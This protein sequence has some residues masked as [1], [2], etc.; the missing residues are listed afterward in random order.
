M[1]RDEGYEVEHQAPLGYRL[2]EFDDRIIG[3]EVSHGLATRIV[4][5]RIIVLDQV[6]STND[7]AWQEALRGAPDGTVIVAEE[8]T[9]GRGR[10]GRSWQAPAHSSLL[11]SIIL[12]APL[13]ADQ[14]DLLTVMSAVAVAQALRENL[15]LQA[16]IRWPNDIMIKGRKVAG[17]LLEGRVLDAASAFVIGIGL[18]VSTEK[19]DF[20]PELRDIAT[21]LALET[22]KTPNR[23]AVMQWVLRSLDVWYRQLRLGEYGDIACRWRELSST[24]GQRVVLA[25]AGNEYRGTVLDLSLEDGLIVRLDGGMT[26]VFP[27]ST[28]TLRQPNNA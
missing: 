2:L 4:G 6:T 13:K 14:G 26:K 12:R 3:A 22:E 23:I 18:N 25:E 11:I 8:Q 24:L 27:P 28:V 5:T 7:I 20:P 15:P 1:L 19:D 16:R 10:M 21:S 9:A 17:I